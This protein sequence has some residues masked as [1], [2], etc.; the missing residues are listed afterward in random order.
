MKH[1]APFATAL[2]FSASALAA[3]PS[4]ESI[5]QLLTI[6][7]SEQV[8]GGARANMDNNL[9]ALIAKATQGRELNAKGKKALE[10]FAKE[11][12]TTMN[13]ELS[14][15]KL[16]PNYIKVYAET[17]TQDEINGMLAFYKT[18]AGQAM[19]QKM[20]VVMQKT[21]IMT[22]QQV[23][24]IMQKIQTSLNKALHEAQENSTPAG[25]MPVPVAP[26]APA[27]K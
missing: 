23:Q 22:Q 21:M 27:A 12:K 16:K 3:A 8:L 4:N 11:Y 18:P 13:S 14:W 17:F 6:T 1:L 10:D 19:I 20:P 2:L 9:Q 24:P 25:G 7:K 26:T 5:E 15:S